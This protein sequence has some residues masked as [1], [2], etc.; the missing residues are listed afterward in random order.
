MLFVNRK[1]LVLLAV[2]VLSAVAR[3]GC[4]PQQLANRGRFGLYVNS[5]E[6]VIRLADDD[7]DIGRAA[8]IISKQAGADIDV[9]E[10]L[11]RIDRMACEVLERLGARAGADIE[12][13]R[14]IR[15]INEYLFE[16]LGFEATE[17][18]DDP[19]DLFLHYVLDRKKGYCLS[20]SILYLSVTERVGLP[21]Y[22]VVVPEHFFARY[23]N[24]RVRFNIETTSRGGTASDEHYRKKF[25]VPGGNELYMQNLGPKETLSCFFNNLGNVYENLG[26]YESALILL[27]RAVN[28]TPKLAMVHT[29]L[30]NVYLARQRTEEAIQQYRKALEIRPDDAATRSNLGGAYMQAWRESGGTNGNETLLDA[31]IFEFRMALEIDEQCIQAREN[32]A[33]A[34]CRK[35]LFNKAL[36]QLEKVL[37]MEPDRASALS[38]LGDAYREMGQNEKAALAYQQALALDQKLVEAHFGLALLYDDQGLTDR[39]IETYNKVVELAE[40]ADL[41][42]AERKSY[43]QYLFGSLQNLGGSYAQKRMYASAIEALHRAIAIESENALAHFNLGVVYSRQGRYSLAAREYSVAIEL[44]EKFGPAHNGL[45][46]CY[47]YL[48]KPQLGWNHIRQAKQ[49]GFEVSP[50]LWEALSKKA[51]GR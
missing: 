30:G 16:E 43:E 27:E 12:G 13:R 25:K 21:V 38:R 17:T 47:Y 48:D 29:N 42:R 15:V 35:G 34:Y 3:A 23:D 24:G 9:D 26:D 51:G 37:E 50:E 18:A 2:L 45:A 5:L 8:L 44:D 49:L 1:T 39:A 10:Y 14:A 32:L 33:G 40:A 46:I 31:A 7:I 28:L 11:G 41:N 6:K 4:E 20:L 22:G 19:K 36:N